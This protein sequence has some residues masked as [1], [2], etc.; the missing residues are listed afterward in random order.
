MQGKVKAGFSL[1]FCG[2]FCLIF[3]TE[4]NPITA[5]VDPTKGKALGSRWP[6]WEVDRQEKF[7][8]A[9]PD[10]VGRAQVALTC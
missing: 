5:H 1:G 9:N 6:I 8:E 3:M 4:N 7:L 10:P 2:V